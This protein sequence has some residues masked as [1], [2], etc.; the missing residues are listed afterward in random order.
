MTTARRTCRKVRFPTEYD[1]GKKL[2]K[3]AQRA[4]RG[5]QVRIPVRYYECPVCG[6][7][8]LTGQPERTDA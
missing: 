7:F 2:K 5:I 1:A 3:I 8:H 4:A 6:G